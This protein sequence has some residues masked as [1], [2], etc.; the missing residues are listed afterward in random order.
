MHKTME[1]QP[2]AKESIDKKEL[3]ETKTYSALFTDKLA[4]MKYR[5]DKNFQEFLKCN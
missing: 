5:S 2:L 4:G 1:L 3:E